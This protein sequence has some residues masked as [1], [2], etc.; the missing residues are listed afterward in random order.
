[1]GRDDVSEL[2]PA[3][4]GGVLKAQI[5]NLSF[6]APYQVLEGRC[7]STSLKDNSSGNLNPNFVTGLYDGFFKARSASGIKQFS[8]LSPLLFIKG[9]KRSCTNNHLSLAAEQQLPTSF[10]GNLRNKFKFK[11][12]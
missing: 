9:G 8:T 7:Y 1:M 5:K 6:V 3:Y 11:F 10:V 2:K 12:K 4:V